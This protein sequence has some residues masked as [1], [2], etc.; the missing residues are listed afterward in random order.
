MRFVLSLL[1]VLLAFAV[2][3]FV[4]HDFRIVDR[5][6]G[7]VTVSKKVSKTCSCEGSCDCCSACLLGGKCVCKPECNCC[8]DCP[9]H[10]K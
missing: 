4:E 3:V 6:N 10:K 7:G 9:G 1:A 5:S 2:G 8:P